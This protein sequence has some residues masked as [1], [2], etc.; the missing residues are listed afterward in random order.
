ME[1]TP[2]PSKKMV[3]AHVRD[4][5]NIEKVVNSHGHDGSLKEEP[6]TCP[7]SIFIIISL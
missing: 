2:K 5:N 6:R 3:S 4:H 7:F 1:C